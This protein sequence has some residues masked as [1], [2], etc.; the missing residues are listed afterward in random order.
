MAALSFSGLFLASVALINFIFVFGTCVEF[1]RFISFRAIYYNITG[2]APQVQESSSRGWSVALQDPAVLRPLAVDLALLL[3][4]VVQHSLLAVEPVK[5]RL[6]AVF[7]VLQ[8][9]FYVFTTALAL[10]VLIRYW[11]P[12]RDAPFLWN[13]STAPWSTWLP[14]LCFIIH[15]LCWL[16]IFS[17]VLIFDYAELMGIKQVYYYCLGLGDPLSMKSPRAQR[18]YAHLRHPV[19]LEVCVVLWA[20]PCLSLDRLLLSGVLSLY[21]T[22]GHSLDTRDYTYLSAQLHNKLD[23]FSRSA[24]PGSNG[25]PVSATTASRKEE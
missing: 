21:L 1:V 2:R 18:L 11:Q 13:S 25:Q 16:I 5:R 7:G 4:F 17:I 19:Y 15:F 6:Q 9:G 20:V 24:Q 23:L 3:L 22:C 8:R 12:V 14:L 10:Q